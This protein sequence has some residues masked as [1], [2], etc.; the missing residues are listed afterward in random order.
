M[1]T[2]RVVAVFGYSSRRKGELDA[3][4]ADR[5]ARAE[6]VADGAR[7]VVL[8]GSREAALMRSAWAGPDVLI[9]CDPEARS[10]ADNAANVAA[11]ARKLGADE[12]V[13]VTSPWHRRRTRILVGAALRGSGIRLSVEAAEGRRPW[14]LLA[15]ELVCMALLPLQ[16]RRAMS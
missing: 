5:L 11:A 6:S 3:I 1:T 14:L 12:L 15:R 10:T 7:A 9:I 2:E 16:L 13:V 8:S 4:C